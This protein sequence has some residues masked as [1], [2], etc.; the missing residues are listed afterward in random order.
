MFVLRPVRARRGFTLIELLVVVAIIALL[1]S[2]L[3]PSLRD[4]REQAKV[5]KCLANYRQLTTSTVQYC[6][7]YNDNFAFVTAVDQAGNALDVCSW[8]YGG[9]TA[10]DFWTSYGGSSLLIPVNRRPLNPYLM[11]GKAPV[12]LYVNN[13]LTKRAEVP[14]VQCPSDF[15]S[16][17]QLFWTGGAASP[18]N[19]ISCY[20]DVGTS[21]QYNLH[22]LFDVIWHGDQAYYSKP[23]GWQN[24]GRELVK[25]VLLKHS[26]TYVMF[27]EDPMDWGLGY[28]IGEIGN[29]GKFMRHSVGFLDGH[30][31]YKAIDTRG[32]CGTGWEAINAEWV[33]TED[34]TPPITYNSRNEYEST[35]TTPK[36]CQ[37]PLTPP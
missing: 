14:V 20:D 31:D 18:P 25:G 6:L 27:L 17:Q 26:A 30:A 33:R 3:L 15:Y 12:D 10:N 11:G 16:H 28:A 37:P 23:M 32:W 34:Y 1:I 36:N 4:A 35:N 21:Y 2:I 19:P 29:H 22:A 13:E 7:D 24:I 8:A 5:A 9:K